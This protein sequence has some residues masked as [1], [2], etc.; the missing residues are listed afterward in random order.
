A[1]PGSDRPPPFSLGPSLPS[2]TAGLASSA[3][4]STSVAQPPGGPTEAVAR[5][6]LVEVLRV[7]VGVLG[8]GGE[9]SA[10]GLEDADDVGALELLDDPRL[11]VAKR[12]PEVHARPLRLA[13]EEPLD[14]GDRVTLGDDHRALDHVLQLTHV[15]G[16]CVAA[17]R[18]HH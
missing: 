8:G 4:D 18:L 7:H 12:Q 3:D 17:E 13:R 9:L 1:T 10:L 14:V 5:Q 6:L 15:A 2:L 11:R 16:P